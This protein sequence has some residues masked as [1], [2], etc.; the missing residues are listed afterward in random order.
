[1]ADRTLNS[2]ELFTGAGGLAIGVSNA[3]FC[4]QATIEQDK[5]ACLTIVSNQQRGIPAVADW[6]VFQTDIR[7]FD[8]TALKIKGEIDL[9]AGGP[10]CQPFS[11][12][13]KHR[14]WDD[15]RDMFPQFFRA[16]R[17]L[18]PKAILVENVKGLLRS[19][20]SK[21]FEYIILQLTYPEIVQKPGEDWVDHLSRLERNHTVGCSSRLSYRVIFHTLNAADYGIPQKRDRVFIVGFRS[22][23]G[24]EWSFPKPTHSQEA[25]LWEQWV[26]GDYWERHNV[27]CSERLEERTK[28]KSS[29]YKLQSSLFPP[30]TQPWHTVRDAVWDLPPP[31]SEEGSSKVLNHAFIPGA[32]KYPGHTGSPLDEPAKTLKA[33]VHGVPGGENMLALPNGEVRYFTIREAAR[34]QTF[35]D[36]Y[37]FPHCWTQTM[38]QLGN[39]VPVALAEILASSIKT[40]LLIAKPVQI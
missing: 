16:V 36:E 27:D 13:G 26:T 11:Q 5:N 22:D 9:L 31:D 15:S 6:P 21:Y 3:G 24:I 28:Q 32:R 29:I 38:R 18:Q 12:G 35:P 20:F 4:H 25:L 37:F 7:H 23:L 34:L 30:L 39:A 10:P 33:G 2:V 17:E 8:F 40:H 1:M 14:G 19:T